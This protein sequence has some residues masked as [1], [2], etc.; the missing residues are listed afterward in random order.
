[1]NFGY[2]GSYL[3]YKG[4]E[5]LIFVFKKIQREKFKIK[6]YLAGN[7]IKDSWYGKIFNITNNIDKNLIKFKNIINLGHI[8]NID[9]FYN[10]IDVLCFPSYL[11]ALGRQVFEAGHY[12]IPSIVCLKRNISDSFVNK[13]TGLSYKNP[14]SLNDLEKII[15]YYCRNKKQIIKMGNNAYKIVKQNF[16]IKKNMEELNKIYFQCTKKN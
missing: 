4:L 12:K 11:N 1:M 7:F 5:D 3:K 8:N 13:K 9:Y 15:K 16:D 2:I 10:K 14:G 6:L